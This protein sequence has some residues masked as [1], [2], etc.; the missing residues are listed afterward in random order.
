[1]LRPIATSLPLGSF[2]FTA[3]TVLLTLLTATSGPW[4]DHLAGI[5]ADVEPLPAQEE[6]RSRSRSL[7]L[8]AA[9]VAA[10]R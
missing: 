6:H 4:F 5:F 2:A 3:G 1:M 8:V 9:W 7:S 10:L